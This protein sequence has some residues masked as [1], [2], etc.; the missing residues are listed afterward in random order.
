MAALDGQT[1]A[2]ER[3]L[4]TVETASFDGM[5]P[6]GSASFES[7]RAMLRALMCPVGPEQAVADADLAV[8]AEPAWSPWRDTALGVAGEA[9]LL[10]GDVD[11]AVELF[12]D[13]C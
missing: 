10:A 3:W 11:R 12:M 6:D 1:T 8:G 13:C 2:A 4:A 5:L 9:Y 7:A